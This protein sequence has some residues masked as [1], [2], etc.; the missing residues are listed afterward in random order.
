MTRD[1]SG[2]AATI[3]VI[4]RSEL[5]RTAR[6]RT[7]MFFVVLLPVVIIVVIGS[8]FGA[9]ESVA[10]GVVDRDGSGSS[11]RLVAALDE[12][13]GVEVETYG[14]RDT[15][16]RDIRTGTV[17]AGVVVPAG[18]G[19]ALDAGDDARVELI[20][21]PT[22]GTAAAVQASVRAAVGDEGVV[23]AAGRAAAAA[24]GTD[25]GAAIEQ[26]TALAGSTPTVRVT[27]ERVDEGRSALGSF[28]Y[29]APA[30]LVLFTFVNTLAVGSLL[31]ME[32]KQGITR[33]MLATPHG[34]GTILAGIGASKF[35]FA[36]LQSTL[37]VVV[38]AVLFGVSWGDPLAAALLV[39]LFAA[40]ATSVGLLVGSTVGHPDQAMAI[41][42]PIAI[43]MGML[44]GCM[45]PLE[46]VPPV[47]RTIGHAVPQAWAMDGWLALVFDG[48]ALGDV[49]GDL[50][51]LAG[52]A[53][54]LGLLA[55]RQL[56][57]ALT[58]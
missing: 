56:R 37:I 40:V 18:Y 36:L 25:V 42:T 19:A 51:V 46:I 15:L 30:N 13:G 58:R 20:A 26:A 3:G 14:S 57:R 31:A 11:R 6:D 53:V 12:A 49:A 5:S 35:L 16:R 45:W 34:T 38:G 44:G 41:G 32:R 9:D 27:S 17:D 52:F 48:A 8:T 28:D 10:V 23:V 43:A 50:A 24:G 54:V 21:D 29:T 4:T 33:R 2:T 47:M 55:R 1:R 7:A 22:S 39:V